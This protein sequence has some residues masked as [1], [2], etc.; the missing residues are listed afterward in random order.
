M[1]IDTSKWNKKC[2]GKYDKRG[3]VWVKKKWKREKYRGKGVFTR[4]GEGTG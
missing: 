4:R 2:R 3:K 1:R